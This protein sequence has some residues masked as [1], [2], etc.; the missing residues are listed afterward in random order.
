MSGRR[1]ARRLRRAAMLALALW[2]PVS[3]AGAAGTVN[4]SLTQQSLATRIPNTLDAL[5]SKFDPEDLGA[6]G[7]LP[8]AEAPSPELLRDAAKPRKLAG[9]AD[10][11]GELPSGSLDIPRPMLR[12]YKSAAER[13]STTHPGCRLH[14]SLVASIGR[15]E[16]GHARSGRIDA[17]GTTVTAI[18]G[19]RL[20]GGPDVAAI[21]DT[22]GGMLDGDPVWDRA[23][24]AMQFI[25]STWARYGVDGNGDGEADPHNVH[26]AIRTAGRYLCAGGVNLR[27][28]ADR[29]GAVFRY[30]H[31]DRYVRTVL[32]W[33]DAYAAGVTPS[34]GALAPEVDR[35]E[36]LA[37]HRL[38]ER[39]PVRTFDPEP[40]PSPGSSAASPEPSAAAAPLPEPPSTPPTPVP[41]TAS[42]VLPAAPSSSNGTPAAQATPQRSAA[43]GSKP[44]DPAMPGPVTP[45]A[46]APSGSTPPSPS[47]SMPPSTP[48]LPAGPEPSGNS[49][50]PSGPEPSTKPPASTGPPPTGSSAPSSSAP[51]S[52]TPSAG[53]SG[54]DASPPAVPSRTP[55][56]P[57]DT[58]VPSSSNPPPSSTAPET[59][60]PSGAPPGS[61]TSPSDSSSGSAPPTSST[62]EVSVPPCAP[63]VLAEGAFVTPERSSGIGDTLESGT[64]SPEE[65]EPG[66]T[67]YVEPAEPGSLELC[68]VPPDYVPP[69]GSPGHGG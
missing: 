3:L 65:A 51:P 46:P 53:E 67:V 37:G 18:L 38:P 57:N 14:W 63:E 13:L 21:P 25:P 44:S 52:T 31:S 23:V 20:S 64:T 68:R 6:T 9:G 49:E 41:P 26:D 19:P 35:T 60:A 59:G 11:L 30:N 24:G 45:S 56:P 62:S 55:V 42:P 40:V 27:N 8:G 15:I 48:K 58:S 28:P 16:S 1:Q 43:H 2:L 7:T 22:D 34:P 39:E 4:G 36:V 32:I 10:V 61:S 12:A 47:P 50:P 17:R 29:A 69:A 66:E 54:S 5:A 33:A